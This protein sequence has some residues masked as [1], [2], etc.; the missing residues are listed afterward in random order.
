MQA[1]FRK[2]GLLVFIL[3]AVVHLLAIIV[4]IAEIR[5]VTKLLLMPVLALTVAVASDHPKK[6]A[7]T[8]ALAFSFFGDLFL[9]LEGTYPFFFIF[10]LLAF[11]ITHILYS[12]FFLSLPSTAASL[13]KIYPSIPVLVMFYGGGLL[14]LLYPS[15]GSFKI[16][17]IIYASIICSMLLCALHVH[18]TVR[19]PT[20]GLFVAGALFFVLSDSLL[21]VN[22]FYHSYPAASVLIMFTYCAA[23]YFIARGFLKYS[24]AG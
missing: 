5:F 15:L 21:A 12:L 4:D 23:Q 10:G 18:R 7:I 14:Y 3:V 22:K 11:L 1:F 2:H 13:L 19:A 17:V 6:Y 24:A 20:G 16:P 9:L 8:T